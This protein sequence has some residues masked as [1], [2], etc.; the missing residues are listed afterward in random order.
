MPFPAGVF[1]F[2]VLKTTYLSIIFKDTTGGIMAIRICPRCQIKEKIPDKGYCAG[3]FIQ[4]NRDYYAKQKA[5]INEF[6]MSK[7]KSLNQ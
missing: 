5:I 6:L 3:C 4:Y 2:N 7:E 1:Y